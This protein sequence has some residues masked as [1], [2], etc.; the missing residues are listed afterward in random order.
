MLLAIMRPHQQRIGMPGQAVNPPALIVSR[1]PS[2]TENQGSG[3]RAP[4]CRTSN[5]AVWPPT[6][7]AIAQGGLC[8]SHPSAYPLPAA[9]RIFYV[10]MEIRLQ[11]QGS[12]KFFGYREIH[13][14]IC[15]RV[16]QIIEFAPD[17]DRASVRHFCAAVCIVTQSAIRTDAGSAAQCLTTCGLHRADDA[18]LRTWARAYRLTKTPTCGCGGHSPALTE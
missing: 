10:G 16:T 15:Q 14:L 7:P 1:T 13:P 4:R 3:A 11:S 8:T 5:L 17:N 9:L 2:Q 12:L 18:P 6:A